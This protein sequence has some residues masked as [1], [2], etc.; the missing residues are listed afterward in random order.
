MLAASNMP[1]DID[2][3]MKRTGR[4]SRMVFVPPPDAQARERLFEMKLADVPVQGLDIARMARDTPHYSGADIEGLV[5]IAKDRVLAH[6]IEGGVDRPLGPDDMEAAR[7]ELQPGTLDWLRTA[8]NLVRYGGADS[9]Y[10]DVERY[11]KDNK[12]A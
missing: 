2:P 6:I 10:R 3:A 9:S 1:W 4:F 7:R 8:R 12:L 5:D 11:L